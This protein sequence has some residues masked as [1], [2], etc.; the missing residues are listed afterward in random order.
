MEEN[1]EESCGMAPLDEP[2]LAGDSLSL[3]S[4]R[5]FTRIRHASPSGGYVSRPSTSTGNIVVTV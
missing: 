2:Y 3:L 4:T 5:C 1:F